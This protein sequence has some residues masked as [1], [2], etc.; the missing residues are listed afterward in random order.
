MVFTSG[1]SWTGGYYETSL[2]YPP[3]TSAVEPLR[4]L[5]SFTALEG[6]F[7]SQLEEPSKQAVVGIESE[8]R[9]NGVLELPGGARVA[10]ASFVTRDDDATEIDF[11]VSVGS[12]ALVWPEVGAFPF[13]AEEHA[14]KWEPRLS[15]LLVALARHVHAR[16]PFLRGLVGFEGIG[17]TDDLRRPGPV[18]DERSVGVIDVRGAA[19]HWW[20][21]TSRGGA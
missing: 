17:F 20:P 3:Q 8:D 9:L 4:A 11:A 2:I 16:Q 6:P 5:W 12:L 21:P 7:A 1:D 19:L 15:A 10:C 13:V 18:P 14:A